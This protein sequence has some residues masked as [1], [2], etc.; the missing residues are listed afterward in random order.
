MKI[1]ALRLS[2]AGSLLSYSESANGAMDFQGRPALRK[3]FQFTSVFSR[4]KIEFAQN[5]FDNL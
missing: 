1:V 5:L 3:F 4:V 2:G